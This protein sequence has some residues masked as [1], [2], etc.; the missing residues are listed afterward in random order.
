MTTGDQVGRSV[1]NCTCNVKV[2]ALEKPLSLTVRSFVAS[3][4]AAVCSSFPAY[5]LED[6]KTGLKVD[7]SDQFRVEL[8][9]TP[10]RSYDALIGISPVSGQLPLI[11]TSKY[12]CGVAFTAIAQNAGI[13]QAQI[14]AEINTQSWGQQARQSMSGTLTFE[15]LVAFELAGITGA[16]FIAIPKMG[17]DHENVRLMLSLLETPKGRTSLTCTATKAGMDSAL[18]LFRTIRDAITPPR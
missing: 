8:D 9:P 3:L 16:E 11:G 1:F 4:I 14:N 13:S 12:L 7:L 15:S 2:V 5:G 6:P 10:D 18:P 17:P